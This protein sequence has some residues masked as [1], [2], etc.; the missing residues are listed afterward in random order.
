VRSLAFFAVMLAAAAA[1]AGP[2]NPAFLG[3]QM[4]GSQVGPCVVEG[5]TRGSAAKAAGLARHDVIQSIDSSPTPNC[6]A[7]LRVIQGHGPGDS[8]K[9]SITRMGRPLQL[10]A[11]LLS[12]AEIMRRR[13]VGQ[14]MLAT[15]LFG[16]ADQRS[17][18]LSALR[19]K[20][21]IVG[22]FDVKRCSGC[23]QVFGKLGD[24]VRAQ[25]DKGVGFPPMALAVT[26][27]A[28]SESKQLTPIGLDVPLALADRDVYEDLVVADAERIN[29]MVIDCRGIVQYVAPIAPNGDD[30]EAAIDELFAAAEQASRRVP[31]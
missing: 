24:W 27:G 26:P 13:L 18:D 5:V 6:D 14:P 19:G 30:T 2:S 20:T 7:V 1:H 16:V 9:L 31:K 12:R 10:T 15:D 29:F 4:G 17:V 23:T 3:I 21:A 25:A 11:E 28:P 22:W 8:I